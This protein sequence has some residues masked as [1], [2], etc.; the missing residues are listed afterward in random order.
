MHTCGAFKDEPRP[1]HHNRSC[2][3][4]VHAA[5]QGQ[6]SPL[7]FSSRGI[8]RT[9]SRTRISKSV[10]R[11]SGGKKLCWCFSCRRFTK[12]PPAGPRCR[13]NRRRSRINSRLCSAAPLSPSVSSVQIPVWT[14][15]GIDPLTTSLK[16]TWFCWLLQLAEAP[17][18]IRMCWFGVGHTPFGCAQFASSN[19]KPAAQKW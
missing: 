17:T 15:G 3:P 10:K 12:F 6:R 2:D 9:L 8:S 4:P 7:H 19:R 5:F 14:R 16:P 13:P 11:I 1:R 18:A